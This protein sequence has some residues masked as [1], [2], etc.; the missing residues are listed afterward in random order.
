[1][2]I[3]QDTF[4]EN[5]AAMVPGQKINGEL[6]N[7]ISRTLESATLKFGAP[8][9][10][11]VGNKGVT[12][13]PAAGKLMGFALLTH[14][15]PETKTRP[16]DSYVTNDEVTVRNS[17]Q[18]AVACATAAVHGNDVFVTPAGVVTATSAGNIAAT[19]W[20]FE[21]SIAVAGNVI[22]VRR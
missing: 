11:G 21:D 13:T 18:V 12:G 2:A 4:V 1:M 14:T 20:V 17:G 10:R 19:G 7:D 22:I 8:V 15:L 9:Y 5:P 3:L 6:Y 16:I